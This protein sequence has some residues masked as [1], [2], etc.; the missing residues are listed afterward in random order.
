[1]PEGQSE[2]LIPLTANLNA[3][4]A[5]SHFAIVGAAD[6]GGAV[7][8]STQLA[9][10]EVA[11][12][13]LQIALDRANVEQGK[14]VELVGKVTVAKPFT[15]PAK[16]K[17]VGLPP[18]LSSP[19]IEITAETKEIRIPVKADAACPPGLVR[20]LF[21]QVTLLHEGEPVQHSTGNVELRVN[22]P[23]RVKTAAK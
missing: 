11:Q 20:N 23:P 17:L 13:Y 18:K 12:P 19:E 7:R 3:T 5:K 6:V 16:V 4:L 2:A 10:I 9:T 14:Q 21:C 22:A 1:M 15:G 8:A